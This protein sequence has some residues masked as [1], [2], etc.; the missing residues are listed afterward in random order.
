MDRRSVVVGF[1]LIAVGVA[2]WIFVVRPFLPPSSALRDRQ[3]VEDAIPLTQ[4]LRYDFRLDDTSG[5]DAAWEKRKPLYSPEMLRRLAE[6][7][8]SFVEFQVAEYG[9]AKDI[10]LA[11]REPQASPPAAAAHARLR[12]AFG[13]EADVM[14]EQYRQA[15]REKAYEASPRVAGGRDPSLLRWDAVYD[16]LVTAWLPMARTR[17]ARITELR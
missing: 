3:V 12:E 8:T 4:T 14:I 15:V 7:L 13:A 2:A 1:S 5:V 16:D 17:I 10:Y 6:A 9:D 11:G